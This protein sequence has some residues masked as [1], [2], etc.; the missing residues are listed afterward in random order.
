[1]EP[2]QNQNFAADCVGSNGKPF[3]CSGL[4]WT[5]AGGGI[6]AS[7]TFTAGAA[8]GNFTV[9]ARADGIAGTATVVVVPPGSGP[10]ITV[11]PTVALQTMTGWEATAQAGQEECDPVTFANYR[12]PLYDRVV[13]ELGI[14]RLRLPILSGTENPVDYFADFLAGRISRDEWRTR[15]L[16]TINDNSDPTTAAAA[17]FQFTQLD[18]SIDNVVAPIRSRVSARGERLY[19]NLNPVDFDARGPLLYRN[20]PAEYAELILTTFQ[21]MQSRYGWT[22]D[23]VEIVLE[24]DNAG[25]SGTQ[26]GHALVAT[27][28]RL[29][30]AGYRPDF[31]AP[32]NASMGGAV[33][34]FDEMVAVPRVTQYLTDLAYHRYTGVSDGNLQAIGARAVAF[35]IRTSMLEH[36]GSGYQD[37][38]QDL[39]LGRN[40]AWQQFILGWCGT[41]D[42]GGAYY[43]ID[44]STP[45]APEIRLGSRTRFLQ[46]YFRDVR[47]GAV[48]HEATSTSGTFEPLAFRNPTGGWVV[49]VKANAGGTF[50]VAGLPGGTYGV[51]YTTAAELRTALPDAPLGP[52]QPLIATIP[53]SGV[54]TITAQ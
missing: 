34:D 8:P 10:T 15:R 31:I 11:V 48:R 37:L 13:T 9:T 46:Q 16:E 43:P 3:P 14:N 22:P 49:V 32:S 54:L 4:A 45:T 42:N 24:A 44:V 29:A 53:A 47:L 21:H 39:T 38:H 50:A 51:T 28:D 35:G 40:S 36:I 23:A 19:V 41:G 12:D 1:M 52:G 33:T 27:G 17:G 6:D 18:F 25:W 5:S 30:A 20:A 7:G 2:G 26:V